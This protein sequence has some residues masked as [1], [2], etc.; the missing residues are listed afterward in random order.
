[1]SALLALWIFSLQASVIDLLPGQDPDDPLLS[2]YVMVDPSASL[3]IEQVQRNFQRFERN[4]SGFINPGTTAGVVWIRFD[5]R[6][7]G[8]RPGKWVISL[9]RALVS[10]GEIYLVTDE[11]TETLLADSTQAFASSYAT[12]GTLAAEFGLEPQSSGSLYIRYRGGNWSGLIPSITT[13]ATLQRHTTTDLLVIFALIG[14]ILTLALY[15]SISFVVID[16]QVVFLYVAAQLAWLA[17][18]VHFCGFT[19][20]YLWPDRP[21]AGQMVAPLTL[22]ISVIAIVQFARHFFGTRSLLP[23]LDMWLVALLIVV[24]SST[25]LLALAD[26]ASDLPRQWF[27]YVIYAG[28]LLSWL[29]VAPLALYATMRWDRDLWPLTVAWSIMLAFFVI[30]QLVW[31]G[32]IDAVPLGPHIYGIFIYGEAV[33]MALG[34]ALRI[35]RIRAQRV[36]SERQLRR[37]LAA[38]LEATQRAVRLAEEREWALGDLAEKG[39]LILAAGHD[40]RQMISSLRH[41]ALGLQRNADPQRVAHAGQALQQIATNL[42][43]V[44]GTA[45][46]GSSSG[47]IGDHTLALE[48]VT[49]DQILTP[50]RLIYGGMAAEK[51]IDLRLRMTSKPLVTDRVLVARIV[52]NLLSNALKYTDCGKVLVACRAGSGGHRFQVFDTGHG[53]QAEALGMLL[54]ADTGA[55]QF[56]LDADGHGAGLH[57]AKALAVRVGGV[58][59]ATSIPGRG[60]R[61]ELFLPDSRGAATPSGRRKV[62][63]LATADRVPDSM[64]QQAQARGLE[65]V[66]TASVTAARETLQLHGAQLLVDE[67]FGGSL[68]GLDLAK[69]FTRAAPQ[70]TVAV[71]TYDRSVEARMRAVE[72]GALILYEPLSVDLL[73]AAAAR[74]P[75]GG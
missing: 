46:D 56:E 75:D 3:D 58:L 2:A 72:A 15:V 59:R 27:L 7:S 1:M 22:S 30:M 26:W 25:L 29:T 61:F 51:G 31:I 60:S 24:A 64:V 57:I 39:R 33:F 14:G 8:Q 10:P 13:S 38:E 6:N 74:Q 32:A 11:R 21:T 69:D 20:V 70:T 55:V 12:Y 37:S 73:L 48:H 66:C 45:I 65:V 62:V 4:T 35:R 67:H 43:E 68:A 23:R 49:P 50:L 54:N 53:L 40:T 16:R 9:N 44:L 19:T 71:M 18:Y 36:E 5:V 42:D 63:V 52:S 17:F 28:T 34:I 41:Y 47:G